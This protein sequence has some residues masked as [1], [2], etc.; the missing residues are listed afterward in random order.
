V[1]LFAFDLLHLD[2]R[3]MRELPYERRRELL[4]DLAPDRPGWRTPRHFLAE[5]NRVLAP[6]REH[7]LEGVVLKRLGNPTC[8]A[9]ATAPG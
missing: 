3:S 2:G 4:L 1:H 9:R 8:R 6:T 5:T 7:G